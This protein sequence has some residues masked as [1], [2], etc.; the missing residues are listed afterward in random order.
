MAASPT[1]LDSGTPRHAVIQGHYPHVSHKAYVGVLA[2]N[3]PFDRRPTLVPRDVAELLLQRMAAERISQKLIRMFP[4]D[5]PLY[6]TPV[7]STGCRFIPSK[8]TSGEIGGARWKDPQSSQWHEEH[9][10]VTHSL[11]ARASMMLKSFSQQQIA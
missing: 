1:L 4:P 11:R 9:G 6:S 3:Q 5:S 7:K 8:L 10:Q 2:H